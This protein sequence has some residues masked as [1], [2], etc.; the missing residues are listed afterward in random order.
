MPTHLWGEGA[1]HT[2]GGGHHQ[3]VGPRDH[4]AALHLTT[5]AREAGSGVACTPARGKDTLVQVDRYPACTAQ[6]EDTLV[7]A[8][9]YLP[10]R[11]RARTLSSR[12]TGTLPAPRSGARMRSSRPTGTLPAPRPG[13]RMRFSRPTGTLPARPSKS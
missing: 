13:V 3:A 8:D 7:Q 4:R 12:L 5:G 10:A 1:E 9:R 11:P 6:G 2:W